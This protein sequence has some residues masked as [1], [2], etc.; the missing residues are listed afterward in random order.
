MIEAI[1]EGSVTQSRATVYIVEDD[2]SVAESIEFLVRH[3]GWRSRRFG[4][5]A[6]FL[7]EAVVAGPRCLI[8]DITLPDLNGLDIQRSLAGS[9][10]MPIIFITGSVDISMTVR[11]MKAGAFE[12][13]A[14]PFDDVAILDA[15]QRAVESSGMAL[16]R[17]EQLQLLKD[18]YGSLTAREREVMGQI[19]A[20]LMNKQIAANLSISEMTVKVHRAKV[21][22]K[23][24]VDSVAALV[25]IDAQL[26]DEL[27]RP[28]SP[29]GSREGAD[30]APP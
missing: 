13:L 26:R 9:R 19:V 15:V 29:S 16:A 10:E 8:L 27:G 23:M 6:A 7:A 28:V 12:F 11:A 24:R 17:L 18:A 5:A 30:A 21:M 3:A 1:R 20:G 22:K 4:T 2:A 25:K 14:K